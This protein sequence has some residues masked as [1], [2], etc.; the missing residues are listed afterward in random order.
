MKC[1]SAVPTPQQ[2]QLPGKE[3][4]IAGS[5]RERKDMYEQW[6]RFVSRH[7]FACQLSDSIQPQAPFHIDAQSRSGNGFTI[8]R[9]ATVSGRSQLLRGPREIYIDPRD[10]YV[11]YASRRGDLEL[12]QNGRRAI[13]RPFTFVLAS[14]SE[15][16]S[17]TK[18]GD[19]DTIDFLMP[20]GFA[21][22]RLV[23]AENCC[24]RPVAAKGGLSDLALNALVSFQQNA[25]LMDESEFRAASCLVGDLLLLALGGC[26]DT[27]ASERSIRA[28]NLRRIKALIRKRFADPELTPKDIARESRLSLSYIHSLFRDDDITLWEFIKAE[29]LQWARQLLGS[30]SHA[31]FTVT[32]A[33]LACGFSSPSQFSTDFRRAFGICPSDLLRRR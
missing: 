28:V 32:D 7:I 22:Q 29:R 3:E 24:M 8:A 11:V 9:F 25:P 27:T 2:T 14:V 21:E 33:A 17:N 6:V 4:R 18:F 26:A 5:V 19:N 20:R 1:I 15:P 30:P 13:C 12:A 31:R 16:L 23:K 10:R